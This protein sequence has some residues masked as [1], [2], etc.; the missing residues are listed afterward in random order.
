M[1]L[2]SRK[3][4]RQQDR[5][6]FCADSMHISCV[7]WSVAFPQVCSLDVWLS[8][9]LHLSPEI[10]LTQGVCLPL[11]QH[12]KKTVLLVAG[13]ECE[14]VWG[15]K[16]VC[17]ATSECACQQQGH[18]EQE[19]T[20]QIFISSRI[21]PTRPR[22]SGDR[23]LWCR[24]QWAAFPP[25]ANAVPASGA[26]QGQGQ[27]IG[28][29]EQQP[30]PRVCLGSTS[31]AQCQPL[32]SRTDWGPLRAEANRAGGWNWLVEEVYST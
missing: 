14:W 4:C 16:C 23:E 12:N 11:Q 20:S 26:G 30:L 15:K 25:T 31:D 9:R 24:Q 28:H 18:K 21:H 7:I 29:G 5:I 2:I 8:I 27:S 13:S 3:V 17:M 19:H 22:R 10:I 6:R 1:A 32:L